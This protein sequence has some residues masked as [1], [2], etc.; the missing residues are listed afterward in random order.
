MKPWKQLTWLGTGTVAVNLPVH[1]IRVGC[2]YIRR[3]PHL[4][5]LASLRRRQDASS[6]QELQE[7]AVRA[8]FVPAKMGNVLEMELY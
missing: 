4:D 2:T 1:K 5:Q 6:S 3:R 8:V 7:R